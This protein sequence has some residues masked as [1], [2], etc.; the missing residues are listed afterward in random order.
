MLSSTEEIEKPVTGERIIFN[1][2]AD[3]APGKSL[4]FELV[5]R[6]HG[7]V[8]AEHIHPH[9]E[10]RFRVLSG[11]LKISIRGNVRSAAAGEEVIIPLNTPHVWWN[12][13]DEETRAE[14]QFTPALKTRRFFETFFGLGRDGKT[15]KKGLPNIFYIAV[16]APEFDIYLAK[17]PI[18]VQK[19]LFAV[20]APIGKLLGYKTYY[21]EYG[22]LHRNVPNLIK[23][24]PTESQGQP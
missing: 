12:G 11:S 1:N 14:I 7:F 13:G 21:P 17:P 23:P 15:D 5:V 19:A 2:S 20:L 22:P 3:E 18:P 10:E 6:P 8:A 9:Q 16:L 4:Q 24:S